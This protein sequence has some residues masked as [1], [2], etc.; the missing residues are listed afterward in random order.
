MHT[1]NTNFD[2]VK[3]K[4]NDPTIDI[5]F[6]TKEDLNKLNQFS[7]SYQKRKPDPNGDLY[8]CLQTDD[9]F[10]TLNFIEDWNNYF[11]CTIL[12]VIGKKTLEQKISNK[13]IGR[14][15]KSN[16]EKYCTNLV[17]TKYQQLL[18]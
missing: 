7:I 4:D 12:A 14:C 15:H 13:R 6:L 9:N 2:D 1:V 5:Y 8:Y 17:R 11:H 3:S 16:F 18:I 10:F